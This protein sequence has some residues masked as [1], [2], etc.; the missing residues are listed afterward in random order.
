VLEAGCIDGQD[1]GATTRQCSFE[2]D[3]RWIV[4]MPGHDQDHS[5]LLSSTR[6]GSADVNVPPAHRRH[7]S[8]TGRI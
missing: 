7:V 3:D 4:S 5:P 6:E 1:V 8:A 2:L